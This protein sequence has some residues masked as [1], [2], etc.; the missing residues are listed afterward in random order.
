MQGSGVSVVSLFVDNLSPELHW[1][2]LWQVFESQDKVLSVFIAS[3]RIRRRMRFAVV[4][5]DSRDDAKRMIEKLNGLKINDSKIS[6]AFAKHVLRTEAGKKKTIEVKWEPKK[7][8]LMP[9]ASRNREASSQKLPAK[10]RIIGH[11]ED[12]DV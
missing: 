8:E 10:R 12:E 2:G 7:D 1:K 5:T 6:V 9:Y 3:K 11:V 4:R